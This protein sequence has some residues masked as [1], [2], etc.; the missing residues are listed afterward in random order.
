M[1]ILLVHTDMLICLQQEKGRGAGRWQARTNTDNCE[2]KEKGSR[3]SDAEE[4]TADSSIKQKRNRKTRKSTIPV[5][6]RHWE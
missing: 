3:E 5:K 4:G 2:R 6:G 1:S